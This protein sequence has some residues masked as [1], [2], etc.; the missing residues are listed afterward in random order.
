MR[1]LATLCFADC[2]LCVYF[3]PEFCHRYEKSWE[4]S[5]LIKICRYLSTLPTKT[6]Y[7]ECNCLDIKLKTCIL[8]FWC[9]T[10]FETIQRNKWLVT[11]NLHH[12]TLPSFCNCLLLFVFSSPRLFRFS[13]LSTLIL[14]QKLAILLARGSHHGGEHS[15]SVNKHYNISICLSKRCITELLL[16]SFSLCW[17]SFS[18]TWLLLCSRANCLSLVADKHASYSGER[19]FKSWPGDRLIWLRFFM[20]F[21]TPTKQMLV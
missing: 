21:L 4:N 7:T 13:V 9:F 16:F 17:G 20:I 1:P 18:L 15:C 6:L 8:L 2:H 12:I 10:S 14:F 5:Q 19:G 11:D 3:L